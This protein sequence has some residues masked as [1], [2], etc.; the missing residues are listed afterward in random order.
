[1]WGAKVGE[2]TL[3]N[4]EESARKMWSVDVTP[5]M[6]ES[7]MQGQPMF[8]RGG[9]TEL[10][11][12]EVALR[13]AIVD[14]MDG[15]GQRVIT[16]DVMGQSVIDYVNGEETSLSKAQ[17]RA[18]ETVSVSSKEEHQQTV[19]SSAAGANVQN[20]LEKLAKLNSLRLII[21]QNSFYFL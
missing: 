4:V 18:L 17:K 3:P 14:L 7:V 13:D 6:K 20:N 1:M 9:V 2:V 16:D 15:Y 8:L 11:P 21:L 10:T 5:E 19:I 12:Q